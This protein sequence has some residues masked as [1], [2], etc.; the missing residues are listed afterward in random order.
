MLSIEVRSVAAST[1]VGLEKLTRFQRRLA[2]GTGRM[3]AD[4]RATP[5][6]RPVFFLGNA[7]SGTTAISALFAKATGQQYSWDICYH[8][9]WSRAGAFLKRGMTLEEMRQRAP[10]A[11]AAGVIKDPDLTCASRE[12]RALYPDSPIFFIVRDPYKNVKSIF[13]RL[14]IAGDLDDAGE[15]LE[16]LPAPWRRQFDASYVGGAPAHYVNLSAR[17]WQCCVDAILDADP[18]SRVVYYEDFSRDKTGL[19]NQLANFAQFPVFEDIS[20]AVNVQYQYKGDPTVSV[21]D[22][23][24]RNLGRITEECR[25]GMIR[26]AYA[27]R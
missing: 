11:F 19:I 26:H 2:R 3:L 1:L 16:R 7:K 21:S 5:H 8:R 12:L 27:L 23:F 25:D 14:G 10:S 22:F 13:E 18:K 17:G 9:R 24:G 15:A 20:N 6:P 4:L